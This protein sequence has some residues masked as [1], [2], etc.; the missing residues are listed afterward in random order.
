M[1]ISGASWLFGCGFALVSIC[2][3]ADTWGPSLPLNPPSDQ[4]A[5]SSSGSEFRGP[6]EEPAKAAPATG[7]ATSDSAR[8]ADPNSGRVDGVCQTIDSAAIANGLP[9]EFFTRLIWQ[10]SRFNTHAISRAGAQGIAQFM[11]TTAHWVGL[12]NPFDAT[13]AIG[14]SAS[15]LDS[16]R[17]QF[18]NLGLAAA[19][20]NA[21][22]KRVADWLSRKRSLP[23]ET[24]AYVQIVTGHTAS[25]WQAVDLT[26]TAS[27]S[28]MPANAIP[29]TEI[30]RLFA[31][32]GGTIS[33]RRP[34]LPGPAVVATP[35]S[36]AW[37]VQLIGESSQ[38]AALASFS[39]LQRTYRS[40][41]G[42]AEPLVIRTP[43][44]ANGSWYRVRIG[45]NTLGDAERLCSSLRAAGGNC[46]VQR[47]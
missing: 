10:E 41:L 17:K 46:L 33:P 39:R 34:Q 11:P 32:G 42:S 23:A 25:E 27:A 18:G 3:H 37:G 40:V 26:A 14:K 7:S 29:C 2:A 5:S 31:E 21:G 15:L 45:A 44:G 38:T 1:R 9:R 6:I 24:R 12:G 19:A 22:P 36:L 43:V 47:N 35:P 28:P 8:A 20:Y 30:V 4:G 16:L 13:E